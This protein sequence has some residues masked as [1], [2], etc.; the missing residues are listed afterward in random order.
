MSI[1][2]RASAVLRGQLR[3]AGRVAPSLAGSTIEIDRLGRQTGEQWA[4]T[5]TATVADDG[6]FAAVWHVNHIGRFALRA[7]ISGHESH[8]AG[9]SPTVMTTIFRPSLATFYGPGFFGHRTACGQVLSHRTLGVANRT[10]PCGTPVA[11]LYRGRTLIVP[12]IDRGPYS[13]G[14]DWD[15]TSATAAALGMTGTETIGAVSLPR[16]S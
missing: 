2:T 5:A 13:N 14:A 8:A 7:I 11:L 16:G 9:A 15:L 6:S 1:S 12:V 10:L 4:P 3:V